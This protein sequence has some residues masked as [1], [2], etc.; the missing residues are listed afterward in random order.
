M[1][2]LSWLGGRDDRALAATQYP[3]RESASE[4][5]DRRAAHREEQAAQQR[6]RDHQR[7]ATSADRA[8][9]SWWDRHR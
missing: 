5:R 2:L 6:R 9:W 8:G 3:H 7:N 4:R 1:A